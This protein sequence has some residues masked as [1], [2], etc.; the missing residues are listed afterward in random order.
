MK[1]GKIMETEHSLL[2]Q[3]SRKE[4]ELKEQC[5]LVCREAETRIHDARVRARRMRDEAEQRGAEEAS[6]YMQN[7]L[8][9]LAIQIRAI[10]ESGERE[11]EKI[12]KAG[13]KRVD[14]AVKRIIEM[15][16]G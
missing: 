1:A 13:E 5:D 7:G 3:I 4:T 8:D 6:R 15:A 12:L 14:I 16:L 11:A 9:E 10:R 2:D